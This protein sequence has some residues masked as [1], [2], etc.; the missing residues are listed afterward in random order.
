M[1]HEPFAKDKKEFRSL[2]L[3][4]KNLN[5]SWAAKEIRKFILQSENSPHNNI[6]ELKNDIKKEWK[7][8]R[9]SLCQR[10]IDKMSA[11]LKLVIDQNGNQIHEY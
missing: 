7:K 3:H 4:L 1:S 6:E 11:R 9:V 8:F 5:P 10:M 2:V